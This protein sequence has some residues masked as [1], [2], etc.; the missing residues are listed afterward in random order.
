MVPYAVRIVLA[1]LLT[2]CVERGD[3]LA[4]EPAGTNEPSAVVVTTMS[5][6]FEHGLAVTNGEL[7]AWGSNADGQLGITDPLDQPLPVPVPSSQRFRSLVAAHDHSCAIDD[8]GDVYCFGLN[9]R[10]QLGQGHREQVTGLVR[11]PLPAPA[12]TVSAQSTHTC[13]LLRDAAIHC[14]GGNAEGQLGQNDP[15]VGADATERDGLSPLRVGTE[16]WLAVATGDGHT[17]AVRLDGALFCWGRNS[18]HELGPETRIQVRGPIRVGSDA[19][20]LEPVPGQQYTCAIKRDGSVWCWG[21]NIG[22]GDNEGF[23]LGIDQPALDTPTRV[24]ELPAIRKLSTSVFHTCAVSADA[25]LYCW[26]RNVE[27]QLGTSDTALRRVPTLVRTG[28]A[29]VST[30]WFTTCILT[31]GGVV[32]CTGKNEHGELGIGTFERP[33]VFTPVRV[34]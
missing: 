9:D 27:G 11:V 7:Y 3:V 31:V 14:W 33:H 8:L 29:D 21:Q 12:A 4:P 1:A 30:S 34:P 26:G 20:W 32:A 15:G 13:A 23:P 18:S 5:A 17:C 2:S 28:V 19:D 25:A 6:G 24:A 22:S 16:A 10:G